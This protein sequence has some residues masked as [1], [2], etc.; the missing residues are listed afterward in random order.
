MTTT[1]GASEGP[2]L[3]TVSWQVT[4]APGTTGVGVQALVMLRLVG[5]SRGRKA[6]TYT[7]SPA[8]VP[9]GLS[10]VRFDESAHEGYM[11]P[12]WKARPV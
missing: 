2:R 7:S 10:P 6:P 3:V 1:S 11:T 8:W 9:S 12:A 5:L 4:V